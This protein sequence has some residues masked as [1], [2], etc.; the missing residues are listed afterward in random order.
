MGRFIGMLIEKKSIIILLLMVI[1]LNLQ[2]QNTGSIHGMVQDVQT[3]EALAGVNVLVLDS[4][5]GASTDLQ[6]KF[7][8]ENLSPG[9]Y[10]LEFIYVGYV[11]QKITDI[12]VSANK[13]AIIDVALQEQAIEGE[14]I[15]VTAGYFVEETMPQPSMIGL[16]RE[17]IRRFPGGFEDVV[18]TVSTLPGVAVNTIGGRNDI[19]VRGGGPSENLYVVN[20]IEVPNINHF[21]T[22]GNSSG[23]LSFINLDLVE[24]ITFS[25]G[26][27]SARYGDK[28]SSTLSLNLAR[29]RDDRLGG[30]LLISATQFGINLEGPLGG[31]GD[32]I[33]S[34]RQS[35]LD[36]IFKAAGL[37]FVPVY[38]DLN[39]ILH[40]DISSKDKLFLLGLAAIDRVDRNQSSEENR[41]T[42]AGIMD[43]TQDQYIS[44]I[45]YRRLYNDGYM[46][47]TLNGI[48][49]K[50]DF[51]QSDKFENEYFSNDSKESEV[52]FK[53]QRFWSINKRFDVLTGI[54][55]KFISVENQ[56]TFADTI[57]DRSGNQISPQELGLTQKI[58]FNQSAS[59]YA[60]YIE[61]DWSLNSALTLNLGLRSDYYTF[62]NNPLYVAP[63]FTMRYKINERISTKL[64]T[65]IYYQSPST[66]WIVNEINKNLDA[67]RNIMTILG[68]DYLIQEDLRM[69]LETYYKN[70]SAL[71]TGS[72]AGVNDY[73]II[74]N[75]GIGYGGQEDD[76]QSFGYFPMVSGA[77]GYAYG[78]EWLLQ[79]KYSRVPCYGQV[80]LTYTKSTYTAGNQ[81]KYPG[82][83]DQ[84]IILNISG[85]YKFNNKW[86]V[87]SKFRL[88]SGI[89][90]TPVYRPSENPLQQG[91]IQNLPQEYLSQRLDTQGIWDVRIDRYFNFKSWR[92]VVFLDIQDVL[93]TKMQSRPRY[94]FWEDTVIERSNIGVLPSIG[95]SA[96]L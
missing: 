43:N 94:D 48:S 75:T 23:S 2:A 62:L 54:S 22:Q 49:Y 66:V 14:T 5:R 15:T 30:K 26:G 24:N 35:Y 28:M 96:E 88:F 37:P 8:I 1:I 12:I 56:T 25:T 4:N 31:Q 16:S 45:N 53:V 9:S 36:L 27:F 77:K 47:F 11:N 71:P 52:G 39:F 19:L 76:F 89:P 79:K 59:K 95:I 67:L 21:A 38:T 18:R 91:D 84:R 51:S 81:Q 10:R 78:F 29:A 86:E 92:L 69:S 87:S 83:Y 74:T 42:N 68:F 3:K 70:Y 73:I 61:L 65:G 32:F 13:P 57:F 55:S 80:S 33:F 50:F 82:Q 63:R 46:D 20:N 41:I 34:A 72:L 64:S 7:K 58:G 90:Y 6:G 60:A 85:G 44:G 40:Y 17:E 93:N